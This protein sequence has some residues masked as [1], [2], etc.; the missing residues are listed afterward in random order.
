MTV[1]F[2]AMNCKSCRNFIQIENVQKRAIRII[3]KRNKITHKEHLL[4]LNI[5]AFKLPVAVFEFNILFRMQIR[6]KYA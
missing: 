4:K 1:H 3:F 2:L 5:L 6:I